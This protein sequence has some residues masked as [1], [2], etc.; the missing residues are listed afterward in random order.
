N[1][2]GTWGDMS[3]LR[4]L[5]KFCH[6]FTESRGLYGALED[7]RSRLDGRMRVLRL[8]SHRWKRHARELRTPRLKASWSSK[9]ARATSEAQE[10]RAWLARTRGI[11]EL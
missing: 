1:R 10:I 4:L 9:A 2:L 6:E 3:N 11:K 5:C 7:Y 8:C